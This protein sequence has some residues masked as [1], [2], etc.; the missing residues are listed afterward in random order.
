MKRYLGSH[1]ARGPYG[2]TPVLKYL[3]SSKRR[4]LR[5]RD[6]M[7]HR[8]HVHEV[9]RLGLLSSVE[10]FA[11]N[12]L[13]LSVIWPWSSTSLTLTFSLKKK[14]E[15]SLET[16]K[17]DSMFDL[18]VPRHINVQQGP[19]QSCSNMLTEIS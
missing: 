10:K 1:P 6:Y 19:R 5:H 12:N 16:L 8:N 11:R 18:G 13:R 3:R 15:Y 7:N 9:V 4:L 14:R 17:V 2:Y